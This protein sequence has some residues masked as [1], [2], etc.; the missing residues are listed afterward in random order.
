MHVN[1]K[2][3]DWR[4][5]ALLLF[6]IGIITFYPVYYILDQFIPEMYLLFF[7]PLWGIIISWGV[8]YALIKGNL[9]SKMTPKYVIYRI[10]SAF[11]I[12]YSMINIFFV[13]IFFVEYLR[14]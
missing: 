4:K 12:I 13:I 1:E 9:L 11:L 10:I 8:I 3:C 5:R 2:S 7:I 14:A 6:I